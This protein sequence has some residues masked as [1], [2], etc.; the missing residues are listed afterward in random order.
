MYIYIFKHHI[1]YIDVHY[2]QYN[3]CSDIG[4]W[5]VKLDRPTDRLTDRPG[6]REVCLPITVNFYFT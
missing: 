1:P 5:E 2:P 4:A 6:Y 3:K